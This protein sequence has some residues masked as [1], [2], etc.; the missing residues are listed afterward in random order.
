MKNYLFYLLF[1]AGASLAAGCGNSSDS[2]SV[3]AAGKHNEN[4]LE[5]TGKDEKAGWFVAKAASA[6]LFEVELGRLASSKAVDPRVKKYGQMM[7]DHHT[8]TNAQLKQTA[9]LK[10]LMV[11]TT[12]G[13]DHQETYN[14]IMSK[15]GAAFDKAY[16]EAMVKD[17]KDVIHEFEEM[18]EEGKDM[19][20]KNF[21]TKTLPTLR[22]H[23]TQAEQLEEQ[24]EELQAN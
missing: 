17:H 21:V 14:E 12:M 5:S 20:I 10:N 4:L 3:D 6:G 8:Q 2:T 7:L 1:A 13:K 16:I 11:P 19:E 24:L 9:D 15:S 18:A 23:L 22:A